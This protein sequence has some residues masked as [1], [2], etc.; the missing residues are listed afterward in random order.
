M[1]E[2][3]RPNPI[4]D[5]RELGA[6]IPDCR[7]ELDSTRHDRRDGDVTIRQLV[8]PCDGRLAVAV[9]DQTRGLQ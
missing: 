6:K 9:R 3:Q 5:T 4:D 8:E 1:R 7:F 2:W